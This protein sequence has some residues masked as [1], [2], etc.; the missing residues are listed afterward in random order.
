MTTRWVIGTTMS[1]KQR[2]RYHGFDE[3]EASLVPVRPVT[4]TKPVG[5]RQMSM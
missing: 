2:D 1:A 3:P 4:A 5:E